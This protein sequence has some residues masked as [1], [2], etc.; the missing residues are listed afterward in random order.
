MHALLLRCSLAPSIDAS[1][2]RPTD[3]PSAVRA[4]PFV[5]SL[6]RSFWRELAYKTVGGGGRRRQYYF[7]CSVGDY[8]RIEKEVI[9]VRNKTRKTESAP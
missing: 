1:R 6:A 2:A 8:I 7:R 3:R 5:R 4:K 9:N